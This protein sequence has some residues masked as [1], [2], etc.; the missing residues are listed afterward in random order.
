MCLGT[1]NAQTMVR[2]AWLGMP[3][4][5]IGYLNKDLRKE[6]LDYVEPPSRTG[7]DGY[8]HERLPV[9]S[10]QR[11][12]EFGVEGAADRRQYITRVLHDQNRGCSL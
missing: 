3:D 4:E 6:H 9:C 11:R 1:A 2:A 7:G 12:D 5:V 10:P 8:T